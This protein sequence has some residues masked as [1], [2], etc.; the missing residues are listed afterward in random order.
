MSGQ[1][2]YGNRDV[3]VPPDG[4]TNRGGEAHEHG[5]T[6][7]T[8]SGRLRW[9]W[10]EPAVWTNRM[11]MALERGVQGGKWFS[12][13]DKVYNPDNLRSSFTKVKANQGKAGVDHVT[14]DDFANRLEKNLRRLVRA[15]RDGT[16]RPQAVRRAY[17][18][19][20]GSKEKRPLG[21]PTV[22]DRVAQG[23][24]RHVLEPIFERDFAEHSYGFRPGRG[25]KDALRRVDAL[26]RQGYTWI[27]D[28]DIKSYFDTIPHDR[29]MTRIEEKIADGRVLALIEAFLH[30][31]ILEGLDQWTPEEGTPQGAVLSPLLA[32]LYLDPFDH[33]MAGL[34]F[35][36]IRYADDFVILCQN[37]PDAR[38]A[39]D[40]ATRWMTENG[41]R[42]HPEKTRI[43]DAREPGGGF[44][45]L[46][47]H[48]QY[49]IRRNRRSGQRAWNW[50]RKP[51]KKSLEKFK[52]AIRRKTRRN[53]GNS[54][55]TIIR[56]VNYTA[57]GWY[58]YFKHS[59]VNELE[60]LDKW[61]RMRLRS[62]LRKRHKGKGHGYGLSHKRWPN[63]F[64]TEQGLFTMATA[65]RT[66]YAA[67]L[68]AHQSS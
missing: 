33:Y 63:A 28:A 30:Q 50:M 44:D 9:Q 31:G 22:R 35:E 38:R 12:L 67:Y 43:V 21:I 34:G 59:I 66:A 25:C 62:I 51:R 16:Y 65:Q 27:V 29:L 13:I 18:S 54:L 61:L 45:F 57:R 53:N 10:A 19:K 47:Y 5:G 49:V 26:L 15:L 40:L 48:F 24:I 39:L 41:L 36:M 42:L 58:E 6:P 8:A 52:D 17:I 68:S 11:L 2:E 55:E 23:A 56:S 1:P 20:P 7:A 37:E 3:S 64:F 46:G 60:T 4:G 32:N 14:V